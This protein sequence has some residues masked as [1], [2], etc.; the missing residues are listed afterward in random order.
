MNLLNKDRAQ[1][2]PRTDVFPA[3]LYNHE[4]PFP[5]EK[6]IAPSRQADDDEKRRELFMEKR[7]AFQTIWYEPAEPA[8]NPK[9]EPLSPAYEPSSSAYDPFE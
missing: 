5:A 3:R 8:K 1:P 9:T 2:I 6:Y 7:K 4:D